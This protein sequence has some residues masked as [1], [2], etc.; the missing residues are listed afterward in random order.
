VLLN[1]ARGS[2]VDTD[3]LV[4]ELVSG[5][6]EAVLDVTEPEVLPPDSPLYEL[7]NVWLTPHLAGAQGGEVHRL[8]EV[9]L[10]ELE[11]YVAGLPLAYP[12]HAEELDRIA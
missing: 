1:T 6:I 3:A 7:P 2:L 8:A 11:R 4:A 12:V 10:G 5:R 9:V